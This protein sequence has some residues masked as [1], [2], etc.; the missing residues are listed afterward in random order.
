MLSPLVEVIQTFLTV[1]DDVERVSDIILLP[2]PPGGHDVVLV[3][4]GHKND[5][6]FL[7]H[8]CLSSYDTLAQRERQSS[9]V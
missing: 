7:A 8:T 9:L 3:V 2:G 6:G 5:K 1:P 4:L